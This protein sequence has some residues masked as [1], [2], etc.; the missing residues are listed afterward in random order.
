MRRVARAPSIKVRLYVSVGGISSRSLLGKAPVRSRTPCR[1]ARMSLLTSAFV[2]V[3]ALQAAPKAT[4]L[5]ALKPK[6]DAIS[7]SFHGRLGY[8]VKRLDNGEEIGIRDTERFPSASTIKTA[9]M[10][11]CFRQIERGELAWDERLET[12]P[13]DKRSESMWVAFLAE[14]VKINI[15]GLI[16]LMM[17]V[18]DNTATVM[19]ADRVGINSIEQLMLSWGL[20]D[21][22][23][24][25]HVDEKDNLRL[26]RLRQIFANMGVTSPRDMGFL[27]EQIYRSKAASPAACQKMIRILS[28]QYWDDF[29]S[30]AIPPTVGVASKAGALNR[31][32]SDS[33]IVFGPRPYIVTVYTDHQKDQRWEDDNE[34]NVA[35]RRISGLIWNHLHPE[36][37][38]NPPPDARKWYPTGGGVE[39]G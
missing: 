8:Y 20:R 33:A 26:Y 19:L 18:S 5:Q 10:V 3:C 4:D 23:C 21:T 38:Y 9:I 15:D 39:G 7:K 1:I 32:R 22:A 24:T 30:Y 25:I 34:G 12:P 37:P 11:E 2:A 36:R 27:L 28:H 16:H 17:N 6:L 35:I 13:A 29:L 14:G 31:S